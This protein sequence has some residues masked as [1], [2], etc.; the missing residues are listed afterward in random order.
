MKNYVMRPDNPVGK[1]FIIGGDSML[2]AVED[3]ASTIGLTVIVND[4]HSTKDPQTIVD[5]GLAVTLGTGKKFRVY[6]AK[7]DIQTG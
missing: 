1:A 2:S 7:S 3:F 5:Y 4:R 6:E